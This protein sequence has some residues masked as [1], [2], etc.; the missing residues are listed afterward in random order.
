MTSKRIGL[1]VVLLAFCAFCGAQDYDITHFR[2]DNDVT[3]VA[4]KDGTLFVGTRTGLIVLRDGVLTKYTSA[5]GLPNDGVLNVAP[6]D[7]ETLYIGPFGPFE[8][9]QW[10][11]EARL[12]GA[13]ITLRDITPVVDPLRRLMNMMAVAPD[14][15]LW[16]VDERGLRR[17]DGE[18][19]RLY[20]GTLSMPDGAIC[21]DVQGR[22]WTSI[23]G[24]FSVTKLEGESWES[25][26]TPFRTSAVGADNDGGVW[27]ISSEGLF[28]LSGDEWKLVSDDPIW[29][30]EMLW[31]KRIVFDGAGNLWAMAGDVLAR[32]D[33][34]SAT[35]FTEA[36]GFTFQAYN[37]RGFPCFSSCAAM[38]PDTVIFGMWGYGVFIVQNSNFTR[39]RFTDC[40]PGGYVNDIIEDSLG[41]IWTRSIETPMLGVH[42]MPGEAGWRQVCGS[43]WLSHS[44]IMLK[45]YASG[46]MALD[47]E[48]AVWV[49]ASYGTIRFGMDEATVF[50][51]ANSELASGG[52]VCADASEAIWFTNPSSLVEQSDG[53]A[54]EFRG[55]TWRRY[56]STDYFNS[57]LPT[58]MTIG[59]DNEVWFR[60]NTG[61]TVY[62]GTDWRQIPF[63]GEEIPHAGRMF[64]DAHG[65]AYLGT[66]AFSGEP[67]SLFVRRPMQ[68]WVKELDV[69]VNDIQAD[70]DGTVWLATDEGIYLNDGDL[71]SVAPF[72]DEIAAAEQNIW[73]AEAGAQ[74]IVIDHDGRKWLGTPRGLSLVEDRGPAQQNVKIE[75]VGPQGGELVVSLLLQ[76]AGRPIAVDAWAAVGLGDQL[77]YL[78]NFSPEP[79][80]I[81][82]T[83][84]A[85]SSGQ[86]EL[87]RLDYDGLP[88]GIYNLYAALSLTGDSSKMI[89][90]VDDKIAYLRVQK[91]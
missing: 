86:V 79:Q 51:E 68:P 48:G 41:R 10:L 33:G 70:S 2:C 14:G 27:L 83:L 55:E 8:G 21:F 17:F 54:V 9:E 11:L 50:N 25:V 75:S 69:L 88:A 90:P 39:A 80:P 81:P 66:T 56:S 5:D 52:Y 31:T 82:L 20:E 89:G 22:V 43:S 73:Y 60:R 42:G 12:D 36:D 44:E 47:L 19:W 85:L 71:W 37:L 78:P 74:R 28:N 84:P 77:F 30:R 18:A 58:D 64:F 6:I 23:S 76:N 61:Y 46:Q 62:D 1:C 65:N 34:V 67:K 49:R 53:A 24:A 38:P 29:G 13:S 45:H 59:P 16:L 91:D 7:A 4:Y 87:L 35:L 72:N 15:T 57:E 3:S 26:L 40:L 63:G 32:F